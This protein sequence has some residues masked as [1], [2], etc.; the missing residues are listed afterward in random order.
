MR[1]LGCSKKSSV[2]LSRLSRLSLLLDTKTN[3][4]ASF[5]LFFLSVLTS[6]FS[7]GSFLWSICSDR[8]LLLLLPLP[9]LRLLLLILLATSSSSPSNVF[10][11]NFFTITA[12][13]Y[14]SLS[15]PTFSFFLFSSFAFLLCLLSVFSVASPRDCHLFVLFF[16]LFV[17]A[18]CTWAGW[19]Y[20]H[21]GS[22]QDEK[23]AKT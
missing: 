8:N 7:A 17:S 20:V 21:C 1:D 22:R 12:R 15:L 3:Q 19:V 4:N 18:R 13:R 16:S 2:L 5:L 9:P 10:R 14:L 23:S 11:N 6:L